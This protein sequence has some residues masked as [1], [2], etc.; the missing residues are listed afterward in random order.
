MG[1]LQSNLDQ[2]ADGIALLVIPVCFQFSYCTWEKFSEL[3]GGYMAHTGFLSL[4]AVCF[5]RTCQG[6]LALMQVQ[7]RPSF[8]EICS[9]CSFMSIMHWG[10]TSERG[11]TVSSL[12]QLFDFISLGLHFDGG[13]TLETS[14]LCSV[15]AR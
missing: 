8:S 9:V 5:W 1:L 13:K 2:S 11:A 4:P 12:L 6:V 10:I 7:E 14:V 3:Y 15:S